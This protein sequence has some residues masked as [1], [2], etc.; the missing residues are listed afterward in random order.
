MD[1]RLAQGHFAL[2]S[3]VPVFCHSER[4][5]PAFVSSGNRALTISGRDT[6]SKNPIAFSETSS[7]RSP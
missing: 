7:S 4:S 2:S 6:K 3:A 5:V 1:L